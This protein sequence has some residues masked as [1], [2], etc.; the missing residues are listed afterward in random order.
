[1]VLD[2]GMSDKLGLV[3]YGPEEKRMMMPELGGKD[4]SDRTAEMIDS[5]IKS[6]IDEA[7]ADA[8]GI[9]EANRE[10]LELVARA[11]LKYETLSGD[12][13][14]A[15]IEGKTLNKPTVGD[16]IDRE[17]S[18]S[19]QAGPGVVGSTPPIAK[20]GVVPEPG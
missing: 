15:I 13:V 12:E 4:Y 5:E 1:M 10:K 6:L 18:K 3:S 11:L 14:R 9:I 20:G 2:W 19:P 16:L 17:Q 7:Y 8:R